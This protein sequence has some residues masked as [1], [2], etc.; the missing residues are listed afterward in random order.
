MRTLVQKAP[1]ILEMSVVD[2]LVPQA[3][4]WLNRAGLGLTRKS[5]GRMAVRCPEVRT[6]WKSEVFAVYL[7]CFFSFESF[8]TPHTLTA[9]RCSCMRVVH[10]LYSFCIYFI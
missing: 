10:A 1:H 5:L 2:E 6:R 8:A 7:V 9:V 3:D 4:R